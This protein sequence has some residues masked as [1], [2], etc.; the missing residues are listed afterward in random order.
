MSF[1]PLKH[2]L[3]YVVVRGSRRPVERPNSSM[4]Y[5]L[6]ALHRTVAMMIFILMI[7]RSKIQC[8]KK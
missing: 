2:S 7:D 4:S 1:W 6:S 3:T 8:R 5:Q